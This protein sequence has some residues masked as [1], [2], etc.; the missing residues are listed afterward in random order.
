MAT[1]IAPTISLVDNA[2]AV[3]LVTTIPVVPT[4]VAFTPAAAAT[5]AGATVNVVRVEAYIAVAVK[6]ITPTTAA[7]VLGSCS[8]LITS[9]LDMFLNENLDSIVLCVLFGLEV[10]PTLLLFYE[11]VE[12]ESSEDS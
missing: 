4:A 6:P 10:G 12:H 5:D 9:S 1:P 7:P 8:L 11:F 3:V 2:A